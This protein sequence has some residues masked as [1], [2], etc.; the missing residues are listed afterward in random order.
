MLAHLGFECSRIKGS[1]QVVVRKISSVHV[2]G[3]TTS[4]NGEDNIP[5]QVGSILCFIDNKQVMKMSVSKQQL[6]I[7]LS[8]PNAISFCNDVAL[9]NELFQNM[10]FGFNV[11]FYANF[12]FAISPITVSQVYDRTM[13]P[14]IKTTSNVASF[15]VGSIITHYN[16]KCI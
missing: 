8:N 6:T 3:N 4:V 7:M 10:S 2:F 9:F 13:L 14:A 1:S 16:D 11:D 12:I 15:Q 5:F